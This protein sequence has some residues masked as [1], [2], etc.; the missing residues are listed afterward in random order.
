[1]EPKAQNE[2]W[3]AVLQA[4]QDDQPNIL[5]VSLHG[6]STDMPAEAT[7]ALP[8]GTRV[9]LASIHPRTNYAD[10]YEEWESDW[11]EWW[12]QTW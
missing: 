11:E 7:N 1:M 8:R 6:N 2:Q 4:T 9:L 5:T 3:L 12:D 10:D